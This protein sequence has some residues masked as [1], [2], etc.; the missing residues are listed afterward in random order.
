[1]QYASMFAQLN[2][3][4]APNADPKQILLLSAIKIRLKSTGCR[5]GSWLKINGLPR[6]ENGSDEGGLVADNCY[7]HMTSMTK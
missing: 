6:A 2:T 7:L 3:S 5:S 1:M 4:A